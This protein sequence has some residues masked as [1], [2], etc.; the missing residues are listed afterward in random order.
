MNNKNTYYLNF[1]LNQLL[2]GKE[3]LKS[4]PMFFNR[5][6]FCKKYAN[7]LWNGADDKTYNDVSLL[8]NQTDIM[9]LRQI[10]KNNFLYLSNWDSLK[11]QEHGDYGFSFIGGNLKFVV[12]PFKE[13]EDG[14]EIKSYD[15]DSG[16]CYDTKLVT[17]KRFFLDTSLSEQGEFVKT[18]QFDPEDM[19]DENTIKKIAEKKQIQVAQYNANRGYALAN[20]QYILVFMILSVVIVWLVYISLKFF[21]T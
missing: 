1:S 2:A 16:T 11:F 20:A 3:L 13:V 6:Y 4:M 21:L 18:C 10:I 19:N 9:S 7:A 5:V 12:I 14:Y 17:D 8:C 15:V